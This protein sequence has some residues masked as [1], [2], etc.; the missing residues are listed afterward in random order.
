MPEFAT[1][2]WK[3]LTILAFSQAWQAAPEQIP[4]RLEIVIDDVL[5]PAEPGFEQLCAVIRAVRASRWSRR[6][7]I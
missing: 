6:A 5:I 1:L 7:L 2:W 3:G 4:A